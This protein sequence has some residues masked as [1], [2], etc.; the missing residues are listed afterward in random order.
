MKSTYRAVRIEVKLGSAVLILPE[1]V[2]DDLRASLRHIIK[3]LSTGTHASDPDCSNMKST[4]L[5]DSNYDCQ[6]H[7]SEK[8]TLGAKR[9]PSGD[10][11]EIFIPAWLIGPDQRGDPASLKLIINLH[12]YNQRPS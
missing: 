6:T 12:R 9:A 1:V 10:G 11:V 4:T 3:L 7:L 2:D 5:T 8:L